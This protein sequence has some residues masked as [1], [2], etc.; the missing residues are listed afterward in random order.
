MNRLLQ[1]TIKFRNPCNAL[2]YVGLFLGYQQYLH[3][4]VISFFMFDRLFILCCFCSVL[5]H[6]PLMFS[7]FSLF[8]Y[9]GYSYNHML[10]LNSQVGLF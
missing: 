6:L 9:P 10:Y 4:A 8:H 5:G 7:N 1:Y 2:T 3:H